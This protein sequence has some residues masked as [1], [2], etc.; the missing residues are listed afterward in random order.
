MLHPGTAE[1]RSV[2]R[3]T[4]TQ[5][6]SGRVTLEWTLDGAPT[7][8]WVEVFDQA[9]ERAEF[10]RW[11]PSAYG[12]PLVVL[13]GVVIWSVIAD[14]VP[15]ALGLVDRALADTNQRLTGARH[16]S[17]ATELWSAS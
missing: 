3:V 6:R 9:S 4:V 10:R 13:E 1:P 2:T 8:E 14:Q 12:R 11:V 7:P 16:P 17:P 5:A 15:A